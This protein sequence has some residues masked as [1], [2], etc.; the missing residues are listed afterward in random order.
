MRGR[1][2]HSLLAALT[3]AALVLAP[4][5]AFGATIPARLSDLLDWPIMTPRPVPG[6]EQAAAAA[7]SSA[8]IGG[9][10]TVTATI[11]D[12]NSATIPIYR[13]YSARSGTHFYTPN[14]EE[15]DM[16]ITRWPTVWSYEGIAYTVN[17]AKNTQ[18]LFRFYNRKNGSHF[19]TSSSS[20]RDM[21]LSQWSNIYQYDGETYKVT[22]HAQSGKT[23]VYRFYNRRN[24]SH[25]YT[26]SPEERDTV[27][28]KWLSIYQLEGVG[29]WLG[30]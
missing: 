1:F 6:E 2:G 14:A 11:Y 20:E 30:Q 3:T 26:S 22:P 18:P 27:L 28:A 12:P 13:F 16:V 10:V 8:A 29:F 4:A 9:T 23:P 5:Q 19:Y 21:V 24:G 7:V 17:P 25:F 15:R